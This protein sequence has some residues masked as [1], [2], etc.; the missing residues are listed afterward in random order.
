MQTRRGGR[1][2]GIGAAT[3]PVFLSLPLDLQTETVDGLDLRPTVLPDPRAPGSDAIQPPR[4]NDRRRQNPS[5]W[6]QRVTESGRAG[7][8]ICR[9]AQGASTE[10]NTARPVAMPADHPLYVQAPP[11]WTPKSG[12]CWNRTTDFVVCLLRLYI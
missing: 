9:A 7:W 11:L 1:S 3:S 6:R 10:C 8:S 2:D 4:R 5:F 12:S